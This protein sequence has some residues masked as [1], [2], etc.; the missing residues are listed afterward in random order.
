MTPGLCFKPGLLLKTLDTYT[1]L[2]ALQPPPQQKSYDP[3]LEE[4]MGV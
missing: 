1:Q 2:L 3:L 4:V